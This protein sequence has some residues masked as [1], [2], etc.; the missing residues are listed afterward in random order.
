MSTENMIKEN[1]RC[2]CICWFTNSFGDYVA[3]LIGW[4][5]NVTIL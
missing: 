4:E 1:M 5:T 3:V 2:E